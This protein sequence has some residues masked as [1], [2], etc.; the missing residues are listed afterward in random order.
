MFSGVGIGGAV[1][2]LGIV[3]Y[4]VQN[5]GD[6]HFTNPHSWVG[7]SALCAS[8]LTAAIGTASHLQYDPSRPKTPF[9]PDK[10]HWWLGRGTVLL[11]YAAIILGLN[12]YGS[13]V[14]LQAG[15]AVMPLFAFL[16]VLFVDLYRWYYAK[17]G[18]TQ[19]FQPYKPNVLLSNHD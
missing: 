6:S 8:L 11:A 4:T 15:F 7:L 2:S 10:S 3:V 9:W 13:A 12:Q 19:F 14:V 1:L 17:R 5:N 16:V 18:Q